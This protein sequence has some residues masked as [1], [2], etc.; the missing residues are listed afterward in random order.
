MRYT[1]V[2]EGYPRRHT[3]SMPLHDLTSATVTS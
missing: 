1:F 3:R 2:I